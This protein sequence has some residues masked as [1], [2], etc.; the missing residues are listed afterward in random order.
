MTIEDAK[1]YIKFTG[2]QNRDRDINE[3]E[4]LIRGI[5]LDDLPPEN[6]TG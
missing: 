4:G 6:W 5:A 2:P 1:A 3:L